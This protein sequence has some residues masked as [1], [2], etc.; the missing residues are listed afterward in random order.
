[1]IIQKIKKGLNF[2]DIN[3]TATDPLGK[4]Y[5][6][7]IH[8]DL[9]QEGEYLAEFTP[10]TQGTYTINV[11]AGKDG[12]KIGSDYQNFLASISK[13]EYYDATLKKE[14]LFNLAHETGG[15]YYEPAGAG[16]IP[17]NLRTKKSKGTSTFSSRQALFSSENS[18]K[19]MNL[20]WELGKT[21]MSL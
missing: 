19:H 20:P 9:S 21:P 8:P 12:K 15:V 7:N 11:E 6:L 3:G 10:N 2:V 13:K 18:Q 14:F 5:E 16:D 17:V 4:M 1:M